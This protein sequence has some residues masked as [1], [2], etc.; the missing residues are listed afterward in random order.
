MIGILALHYAYLFFSTVFFEIDF[1]SK[2]YNKP[3][4]ITLNYSKG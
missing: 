3:M 4:P 1:I 2:T